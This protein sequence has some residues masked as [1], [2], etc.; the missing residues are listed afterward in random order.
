MLLYR[1]AMLAAGLA[2][3]AVGVAPARAAFAPV[4][5]FESLSLGGLNGQNGWNANA[6][7]NVVVD[8]GDSGNRL[9]SVTTISGNAW[10][11]IPTIA[12]SSSAATLYYQVKRLDLLNTSTGLS[13]LAAPGTTDFA[14]FEVQLNVNITSNPQSF[15]IRDAGAFDTLSATGTGQT[16]FNS[17]TAYHIFH[18]VDNAANTSKV[19]IQSATDAAPVLQFNGSQQDFTFRNGAA[20]NDLLTFLA[21]SGAAGT[22]VAGHVGPLYI[23]NIYVDTTGSNLVAPAPLISGVI[24]EPSSVA[25]LAMIA[26]PG[27]LR[28][29]RT[30]TV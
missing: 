27:L 4:E 16:D 22:G 9:L 3:V 29:R 19:Y 12:D 8:P 7:A 15:R 26:A 6:G 11:S 1:S 13:D 25:V 28:R 5:T 14:D 10:K 2:V 23:D 24:P 17:Q 30:A 20:A 18:V 21:R